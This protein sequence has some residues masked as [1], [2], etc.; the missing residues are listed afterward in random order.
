MNRSHWKNMPSALY[1][2]AM[3]ENRGKQGKTVISPNSAQLTARNAMNCPKCNS[4][5]DESGDNSIRVAECYFCG[6]RLVFD[7]QEEENGS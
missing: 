2:I 7:E 5:M 1:H 3:N 4:R 6:F